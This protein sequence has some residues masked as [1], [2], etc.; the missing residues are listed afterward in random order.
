[1]EIILQ[2]S[3][4]F[5][6]SHNFG[7]MAERKNNNSLATNSNGTL[8]EQPKEDR[9][10]VT[11]TMS[12]EKIESL[13]INFDNQMSESWKSVRFKIDQ[14]ED[15]IVVQVVETLSNKVLKQIPDDEFVKLTLSLDP[16]K[17]VLVDEIS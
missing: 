17:G 8:V 3:T 1:M 10:V 7:R 14:K 2:N 12:I 13:V 16:T 11:N 6:I 15:K 9:A 5:S 4:P